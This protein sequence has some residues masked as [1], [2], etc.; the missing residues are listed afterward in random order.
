MKPIIIIPI[1]KNASTSLNLMFAKNNIL[2]KTDFDH[3]KL[4]EILPLINEK[5]NIIIACIRNPYHRLISF[6]YWTISWNNKYC[7]L[8]EYIE[9]K[10]SKNINLV[11]DKIIMNELLKSQIIDNDNE[12]FLEKYF[13]KKKE[14]KKIKLIKDINR[15]KIVKKYEQ[16]GFTR[17]LEKTLNDKNYF[18]AYY[19]FIHNSQLSFIKPKDKVKYIIKQENLHDDVNSVLKEL[20]L[21]KINNKK[22]NISINNSDTYTNEMNYLKKNK[23]LLSKINNLLKED[24]EYFQYDK[25]I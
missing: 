20:N 5:N 8:R 12:I 24:L 25:L 18:D 21:E 23:L 9:N 10:F 16:E 17:T 15:Y 3:K 7:K 22:R 19:K 4:S 11:N 1:P 13:N 6:Y 2:N 14:H